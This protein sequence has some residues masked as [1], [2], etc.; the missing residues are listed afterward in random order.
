M[1]ADVRTLHELHD[2]ANLA[3][4]RRESLVLVLHTPGGQVYR[5]IVNV[6]GLERQE[7]TKT[8]EQA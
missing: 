1:R 8:G 6:H 4:D 2:A 3:L 5:F 7:C